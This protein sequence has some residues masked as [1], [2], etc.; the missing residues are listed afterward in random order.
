MIHKTF[1]IGIIL[2]A[3]LIFNRSIRQSVSSVQEYNRLSLEAY[4]SEDYIT[5]QKLILKLVELEPENYRHRRQ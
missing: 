2:L 1:L 5:Y 4:Q 3:V